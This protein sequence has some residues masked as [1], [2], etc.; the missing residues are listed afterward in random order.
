MKR[1]L[2]SPL[3]WFVLALALACG[4]GRAQPWVFV[5]ADGRPVALQGLQVGAT[6]QLRVSGW[7]GFGTWSGNGRALLNDACYEF[8]A[9]GVANPLPVVQNDLGVSVCGPYQADHVYAS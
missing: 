1:S 3:V 6:Y 4:S 8:N 7:M 5:P 9:T 2:P